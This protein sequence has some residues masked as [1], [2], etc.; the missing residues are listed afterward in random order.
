MTFF[1]FLNRKSLVWLTLPA[2]LIAGC[3]NKPG[4]RS[5]QFQL[6][7]ID[8]QTQEP[9]PG[10][11]V[12]VGDYQ[13]Q[14]DN[15][16]QIQIADLPPGAY[17]M[18]LERPYYAAADYDLDY[19]G[20]PVDN[21][22]MK[23]AVKLD[24][25]LLYRASRTKGH[26]IYQ[27]DLATRRATPLVAYPSDE[28]DPVRVSD[29][30]IIFSSDLEPGNKKDLYLYDRT[31]DLAQALCSSKENEDQPSVSANQAEHLLIFHSM[32]SGSGALYRYRL[33]S[34]PPEPPLKLTA[35]YE[36][37]IHPEGTQI[38]YINSNKLWLAD[39][40]AAQLVNIRTLTDQTDPGNPCWSP[41]GKYLAFDARANPQ[42]PRYIF[43]L[44]PADHSV[45]QVTADFGAKHVANHQ[46]P[47]WLRAADGTWLLFFAAAIAYDT[48]TDIYCVKFDPQRTDAAPVDPYDWLMLSSGSGN[49]D[50]PSWG[51]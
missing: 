25:T 37:A 15:A 5:G 18:H 22:Y 38:A 26:D 9:I 29:T 4:P 23:S 49:K 11:S 47:G 32:R 42:G 34:N 27:L 46:H 13:L 35:G 48:R 31:A 40:T 17:R 12:R 2:I 10:V 7:V 36:P 19:V 30:Q 6:K 24:G 8:A 51:R 3:L 50:E 20:R 14:S 41:D 39:L 43:V 28:G 1:F 21:V 16:G 44:N 45:R 33:T